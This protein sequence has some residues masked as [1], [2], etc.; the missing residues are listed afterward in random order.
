MHSTWTY[1]LSVR[2]QNGC[3]WN[4]ISLLEKRVGFMNCYH[5]NHLRK[6]LKHSCVFHFLVV[7]SISTPHGVSLTFEV[8]M[9]HDAFLSV[10]LLNLFISERNFKFQTVKLY[11]G[12]FFLITLIIFL[13]FL[14]TI[15]F[16]CFFFVY[17]WLTDGNTFRWNY[18]ALSKYKYSRSITKTNR[19]VWIW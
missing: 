3:Q 19:M 9:L 4:Q 2:Y 13:P 16:P 8:K 1:N 10:G 17:V 12:S 15:Y 5:L 6:L 14:V 7:F 11:F 18:I